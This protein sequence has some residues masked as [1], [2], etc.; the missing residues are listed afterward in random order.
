MP[1]EN[2]VT[3]SEGTLPP[4]PVARVTLPEGQVSR[5]AL[6]LV[7]GEQIVGEGVIEY[8]NINE[9]ENSI[10]VVFQDGTTAEHAINENI[11]CWETPR[12]A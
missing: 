11:I 7:T 4:T 10:T 6:L 9:A 1:D 8:Y 2:D 12:N 3:P 5:P